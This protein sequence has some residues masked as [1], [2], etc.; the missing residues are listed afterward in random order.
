VDVTDD[1][2]EITVDVGGWPPT[3]A[4][5][6]PGHPRG[7]RVL[8][9]LRAAREAAAEQDWA[10]TG[11]D[12]GLE[13][14][15]RGPGRPPADA[16]NYLGGIGDTLQDKL[17]RPWVEAGELGG[18]LAEVALFH[19]DRQIRAVRYAEEQ[20][21]QPSYRLR[22]YL[23]V[24]AEPP[25]PLPAAE[26]GYLAKL[27]ALGPWLA[28]LPDGPREAGFAELEQVTGVPLPASARV[29]RSHWTAG[30]PLSRII[31]DAGWSAT[32]VDLKA[33]T[34]TLIR[35]TGG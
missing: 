9:L 4:F 30:S 7:E 34:L 10:L 14:L 28:A 26:A 35:R 18:E 27:A 21:E 8:T 13:L 31:A 16:A 20:A 17:S 33:E 12:L 19:D 24:P 2:G 25:R 22:L 29:H 15:V 6:T 11:A 32:R 1:N 23:L 5:L 3:K